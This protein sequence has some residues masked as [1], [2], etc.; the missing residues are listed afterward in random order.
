MK[1]F[2]KFSLAILSISFLLGGVGTLSYLANQ[3]VKKTVKQ[4]LLKGDRIRNTLTNI[5]LNLRKIESTTYSNIQLNSENTRIPKNQVFNLFDTLE[6]DTDILIKET[7]K[8]LRFDLNSNLEKKIEAEKNEELHDEL[9]LVVLTNK[10]KD[11]NQELKSII[12]LLFNNHLND[13][14]KYRSIQEFEYLLNNQIFPL[15]E[16]YQKGFSED[17]KEKTEVVITYL[18]NNDLIILSATG[19]ALILSIIIGLY[20]AHKISRPISQLTTGITLTSN[21]QRDINLPELNN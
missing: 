10:L 12:T 14:E 6:K 1:I 17:Q 20:A 5:E 15:L 16:S 9:E 19:S 13:Y 8:L 4:G 11:K 18:N 2:Q 21:G 3:E 7:E